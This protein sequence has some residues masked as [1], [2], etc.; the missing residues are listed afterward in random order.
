MKLMALLLMCLVCSA[1]MAGQR[2]GPYSCL[3]LT[4]MPDGTQVR[5]V[6]IEL[7]EYACYVRYENTWL[8]DEYV[9]LAMG[10]VRLREHYPPR[11]LLFRCDPLPGCAAWMRARKMCEQPLTQ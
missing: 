7:G 6:P 4:K 2:C 9:T 11:S 3:E 1:V 5:V 10:P 8:V